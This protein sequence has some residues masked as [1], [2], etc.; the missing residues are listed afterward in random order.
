MIVRLVKGVWELADEK[1][2]TRLYMYLKR[3]LEEQSLVRCL[4]EILDKLTVQ[5]F[6]VGW[7]S[8]VQ[9][10][11]VGSN[12]AFYVADLLYSLF[13]QDLLDSCKACLCP[14]SI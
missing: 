9:M 2:A 13:L 3:V 5:G 8:L 11:K 12:Q 10:A 7:P 1:T 4:P 14:T 6:P